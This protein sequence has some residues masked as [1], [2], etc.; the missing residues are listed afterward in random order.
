[1][2]IT[3]FDIKTG[4]VLQQPNPETLQLEP[5]QKLV[6]HSYLEAWLRR[7]EL[8]NAAFFV[9]EFYPG[10]DE[11]DRL[12]LEEDGKVLVFA[13]GKKGYFTDPET[14]KLMIEGDRKIQPIYA[15][16]GTAAHNA[17]AYGSLIASDG[18]ASSMRGSCKILVIDDEGDLSSEFLSLDDRLLNKMSDGTMLVSEEVIRSLLTPEDEALN[19]LTL[20]T[21]FRAASPDFPGMA[22]G[23]LTYSK[24]CEDLAI[25][26][27]VNSERKISWLGHYPRTAINFAPVG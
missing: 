13:N 1:M 5:K 4:K 7:H 25:I 10:V 21:Q 20:V 26:L 24:W 16:D 6:D 22:K 12:R 14:A 19:P 2:L 27:K 17:I 18:I 3:Q 23:T 15:G 9:G 11:S 8:E